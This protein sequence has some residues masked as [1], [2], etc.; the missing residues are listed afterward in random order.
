MVDREPRTQCA[1][2]APPSP[3]V[4]DF[5]AGQGLA[6]S[7]TSGGYFLQGGHARGQPAEGL[8]VVYNFGD[9]PARGKL[10]LEGDAWILAGGSRQMAMELA[11][12]DRREV[13][14][15][16]APPG[17]RFVAHRVRAVWREADLAARKA[18]SG[19]RI[20]A[21][22]QV[23]KMPPPQPTPKVTKSEAV[24]RG[25]RTPVAGQALFEMYFR[26]LDGNLYGTWP[27]LTATEQWARYME[28]MGN[29]SMAFYGRADPPWRFED[30]QPAAL[31]LFLR[32]AELPATFEI[33]WAQ[34]AEFAAP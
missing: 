2:S 28:R 24:S 14:V 31:V 1:A 8:L 6:Q 26:T 27:R 33:R 15:R 10:V 30:N 9:R 16:I 25:V 32:P 11:P 29:F 17:N 13:S 7:K 21:D 5:V 23:E 34:V 18:E 22:E 4:V 12:G 19:G 3:V 20:T